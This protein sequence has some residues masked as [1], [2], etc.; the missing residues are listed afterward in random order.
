MLVEKCTYVKINAKIIVKNIKCPLFPH[1]LLFAVIGRGVVTR[2]TCHLPFRQI[3]HGPGNCETGQ[4]S[5]LIGNLYDFSKALNTYYR[6][7]VTI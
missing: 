2:G 6:L 5:G 3:G 1:L 4:V 7:P